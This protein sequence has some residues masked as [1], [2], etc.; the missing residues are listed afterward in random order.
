M[1]EETNPLHGATI[2]ELNTSAEGSGFNAETGTLTLKFTTASSIEAGKPY[3]VKWEDSSG[4]VDPVVFNGVTISSTSPTSITSNDRKVTFVGTYSP[5][6]LT[7]D[8]TSN[9]YMGAG[10]TLYYPNED[11]FFVRSFRAYFHIDPSA[12]VKGY[13][14]DFGEDDAT[15]IDHST[16]NIEHSERA[17]Y[18][19]AGQRIN[20]MQK[21]INIVNG[22]K[23]LK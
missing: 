19:V 7:K 13:V 22:K 10:S 3:I 1:A 5:V 18:N 14:M 23:I 2:K 11:D 20:T 8:D 16:L 15:S 9:L 4:L 6:S 21:G 17:I 12:S